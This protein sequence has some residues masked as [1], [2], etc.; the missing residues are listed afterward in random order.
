[1][2]KVVVEAV[3]V[4]IKIVDIKNK[5]EAIKPPIFLL[6]QNDI[7][8]K[9]QDISLYQLQMQTYDKALQKFQNLH[10]ELDS[11]YSAIN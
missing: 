2:E 6:T 9:Y 8:V 10:K 7:F 3:K 4:A 11:N 5:M 1:M